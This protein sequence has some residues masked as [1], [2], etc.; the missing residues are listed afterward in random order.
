[1]RDACANMWLLRHKALGFGIDYQMYIATVDAP[2]VDS[3][4]LT[5]AV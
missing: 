4:A 5:V 2:P 3:H 1:M